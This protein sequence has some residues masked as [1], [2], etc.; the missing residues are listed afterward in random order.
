MKPSTRSV[1]AGTLTVLLSLTAIV[2]VTT[3]IAQAKVTTASS[4]R[5]DATGSLTGALPIIE[6]TG[7]PVALGVTQAGIPPLIRVNAL[8]TPPPGTAHLTGQMLCGNT[9]KS[10]HTVFLILID[11]SSYYILQGNYTDEAGR[12]L[13][14]DL[15]AGKYAV[16]GEMP[17]SLPTQV[18]VLNAGGVTDV[19]GI[20]LSPLACN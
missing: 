16:T 3:L 19:G 7:T 9:P 14:S 8:P 5:Q 6:P 13:F 10:L 12:W 11:G 4:P 20:S 1:F 18:I 2:V 17:A 15:P